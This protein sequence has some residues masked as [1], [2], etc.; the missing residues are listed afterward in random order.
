MVRKS[1]VARHALRHDRPAKAQVLLIVGRAQVPAAP[2]DVPGK[3]HL[4]QVSVDGRQIRARMVPRT[5]DPLDG[6]DALV[7]G[8]SRC[9]QAIFALKKRVCAHEGL[10]VKIRS[11]VAHR[12]RRKRFRGGRGV[13]TGQRAAHPG[14]M[15]RHV[16][17]LVTGCAGFVPHIRGLRRLRGQG[18]AARRRLPC[19]ASRQ[20]CK[21]DGGDGWPNGRPAHALLAIFWT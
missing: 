18:V 3:R 20:P 16:I 7:Q 19:D 13:E 5:D 14:P 15:I 17:G 1:V 2:L 9:V 21:Q 12:R 11:F 4:R 6:V 10:V 8:L